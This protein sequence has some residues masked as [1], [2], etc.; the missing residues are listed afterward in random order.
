MKYLN[1][2]SLK[3]N[4]HGRYKIRLTNKFTLSIQTCTP[5]RSSKEQFCKDSLDP[6]F[7]QQ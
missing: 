6:L 1:C 3:K 5:T 7:T 2:G 4:I